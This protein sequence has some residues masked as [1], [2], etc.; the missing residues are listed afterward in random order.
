MNT[1]LLR[2]AAPMLVGALLPAGCS[3][4]NVQRSGY[5]SVEFVRLQPCLDERDSE[6]SMER[7]RYEDYQTERQRLQEQQP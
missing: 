3:W 4:Q 6:C 1:P 2:F 7:T 5:K